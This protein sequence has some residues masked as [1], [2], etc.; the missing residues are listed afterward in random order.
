[1]VDRLIK[2]LFYAFFLLVPLS[3]WKVKLYGVPVSAD[4][5]IA[6]LIIILFAVKTLLFKDRKISIMRFK[7]TI[8]SNRFWII[9][10]VYVAACLLSFTKSI[11]IKA[12]IDEMMRFLSYIFLF[13]IIINEF[14][15]SKYIYRILSF[16][17]I[18]CSFAVLFGILQAFTGIGL[19]PA[20]NVEQYFGVSRRI[21]STMYNPN[22]FASFIM[23]VS[24]PV[25]MISLYIKQKKFKV[26]L[27]ILFGLLSVNLLLTFSREGWIGYVIGFVA[28]ALI[29]N[30]KLLYFLIVLPLSL[31]VGSIRER[32]LSTFDFTVYYN[33]SRIKLWLTGLVMIRDN[34]IL[35]VGMGNSIYWYDRVTDRYHELRAGFTMYPLH[36]SYIKVEAETGILGILSFLATLYYIL[37]RSLK[38]YRKALD[39]V[40]KGLS[41]GFFVSCIGYLFMNFFDNCLFDPQTAVF[42]WLIF[43]LITALNR[44]NGSAENSK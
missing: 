14:K 22:N 7:D 28:M 8:S 18:S 37:S 6:F 44:V 3:S 26:F 38:V 30:K 19:D 9:I 5:V 20:F 24:Y 11:N 36:N 29:Y 2:Y 25:L 33:M 31:L 21:G 17:A 10:A 40:L 42:F 34:P 23:L 13:Y 16:F 12:S 35:G 39:P 15:D 27:L 43:A 4:F 1:M 32:V 41:G